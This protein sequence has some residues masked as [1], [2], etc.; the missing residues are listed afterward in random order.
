M[1]VQHKKKRF[2]IEVASNKGKPIVTNKGF[3]NFLRG[4]RFMGCD[5]ITEKVFEDCF[6]LEVK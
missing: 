3:V 5:T 6:S 4:A 1:E 2:V